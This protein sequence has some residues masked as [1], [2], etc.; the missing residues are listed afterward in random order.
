[1]WEEKIVKIICKL[2]KVFPP[3]FFNSMEH[4]TIHLSCE[5]KVGEPV[6]FRWMY[7]FER[8]MHDLKKKVLNKDRVE[9]SI[10]EANILSEI[11]FFSLHYF[12]S[13]I[14]TRLNRLP[15]NIVSKNDNIDGCLSVFRNR[16]QPLGGRNAWASNVTK[17]IK[18][19][20]TLCFA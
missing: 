7:P 19:N 13:N 2:E 18:G 17:G 5:V 11:S 8:K 12:G 10:Y 14:Q 6:R 3:A 9:A 1:M 16:G 4:L 20:R 15:R